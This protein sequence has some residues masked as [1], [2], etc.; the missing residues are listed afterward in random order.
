MASASVGTLDAAALGWAPPRADV[1]M[2]RRRRAL[3]DITE[4]L[5]QRQQQRR[6]EPR[7]AVKRSASA[8]RRE[9]ES[10]AAQLGVSAAGCD[11]AAAAAMVQ[12][13]RN[14][15][16][17]DCGG[18]DMS[19]L[20]AA[21]AE[22]PMNCPKRRRPA[23][24][25]AAAW[26]PAAPAAEAAPPGTVPARA[27]LP[28]FRCN[29]TW[30]GTR[31][32]P[33][34]LSPPQDRLAETWPRRAGWGG[35]PVHRKDLSPPAPFY[36]SPPEASPS[37][38][39]WPRDQVRMSESRSPSSGAAT[40]PARMACSPPWIAPA[41]SPCWW[42]PQH[43][44]SQ[45]GRQQKV[46][47]PD[48]SGAEPGRIVSGVYCDCT[49]SPQPHSELIA[50]ARLPSVA[51]TPRGGCPS[52]PRQGRTPSPTL[53][54]H[55]EWV[56]P[57][58]MSRGQS[59]PPTPF[60]LQR[61]PQVL[62]ETSPQPAEHAALPDPLTARPRRAPRVSVAP[63]RSCAQVRNNGRTGYRAAAA[64]AKWAAEQRP[65]AAAARQRRA[66]FADADDE[67]MADDGMRE[68]SGSPPTAPSPQ[69]HY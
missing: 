31:V 3:S 39:S 33:P 51:A 14:S 56:A 21:L 67:V 55:S 10:L 18:F 49:P 44:R 30:T 63:R 7:L 57:L 13:Y 48:M 2:A 6:P 38:G 20:I 32:P 25:A 37:S 54:V 62:G 9:R 60:A 47:P 64:T 36:A 46:S 23:P 24:S 27:V 65:R 8:R 29:P 34:T 69:R 45:L 17:H 1:A 66:R 58:R 26:Q 19:S 52:M 53:P 59:S 41:A 16:P 50:P 12:Q 5:A 61:R 40:T 35:S 43:L 15:R 22:S 28:D 68:D 4:S 11:A 42:A